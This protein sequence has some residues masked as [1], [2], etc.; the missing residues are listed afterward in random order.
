MSFSCSYSYS[1]EESE[2]TIRYIPSV[3]TLA[4]IAAETGTVW[5]SL[6]MTM[7]MLTGVH[8]L[9]RSVNQALTCP[10]W[11]VPTA[12]DTASG[13]PSGTQNSNDVGPTAAISPKHHCIQCYTQLSQPS[14]GP[15]LTLGWLGS[16]VVRTPD[17]WREVTSST[18]AVASYS[19]I[20]QLSLP[21]L[22]GR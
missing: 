11:T 2:T 19:S 5:L 18:P 22:R 9:Q 3:D 17:L 4:T 12:G 6:M 14:V 16:V 7:M 21:S 1:A 8:E 13:T 10:G 15:T 20:G